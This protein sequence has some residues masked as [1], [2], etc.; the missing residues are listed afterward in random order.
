MLRVLPIIA[1][2]LLLVFSMVD[3]VQSP[4]SRVRNLPKWV[5]IVLILLVPLAGPIAWLI[6]GRPIV[7]ATPQAP[8]AAPRPSRA[9]DDDPDFLAR[10]KPEAEHERLLR[11]WEAD[12]RR[13]EAELRDTDDESPDQ[14]PDT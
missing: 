9:P 11:Q 12:L 4:D 7:P 3:C 2:I 8:S 10:L 6:G 13:R 14:T 1:A 5:W